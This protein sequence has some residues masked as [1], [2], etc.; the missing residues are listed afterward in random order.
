MTYDKLLWDAG[1]TL[2][3][4]VFVAN[5]GEAFRGR[6]EA[7][8]ADWQGNIL[9]REAFEADIP[10]DGGAEAGAF[11]VVIP[12]SQALVVTLTLTGCGEPV[13][14]QYQ[15]FVRNAQ[16]FADREVAESRVLAVKGRA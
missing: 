12:A 7:V 4:R 5:D 1:E 14:T 8:V 6:V 11:S 9:L 2:Y 10:A 16:G 3:S 15:L 13:E